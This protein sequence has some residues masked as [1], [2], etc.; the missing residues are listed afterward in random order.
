MIL[1]EY[2]PYCASHSKLLP[3]KQ[4]NRLD[5]WKLVW[6]Q[7]KRICH[8]HTRTR[9]KETFSNESLFL[10]LPLRLVQT[11]GR[12]F[13]HF[14]LQFTLNFV[15]RRKPERRTRQTNGP[16]IDG[17][18]MLFQIARGIPRILKM[19]KFS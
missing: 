9:K 13:D 11:Q 17:A 19:L 15:H 8:T 10:I 6:L 3:V 1:V 7:A 5:N 2:L 4:R 16:R 18:G 14:R 12:L